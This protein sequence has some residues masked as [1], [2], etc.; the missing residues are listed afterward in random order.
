MVASTDIEIGTNICV[1]YRWS[2]WAEKLRYYGN[3]IPPALRAEICRYY[4]Q[5][6][7]DVI[8]ANMYRLENPQAEVIA[9]LTDPTFHPPAEPLGT[10]I[11]ANIDDLVTFGQSFVAALAHTTPYRPSASTTPHCIPSKTPPLLIWIT[12]NGTS[13]RALVDTGACETVISAK[14][15]QRMGWHVGAIPCQRNIPLR[16]ADLS[17]CSDQ[18]LTITQQVHITL[19]DKDNVGYEVPLG[20]ATIMQSVVCDIILGLP[21]CVGNTLII[22]TAA[23]TIFSKYL[24]ITFPTIKDLGHPEASDVA[25][26]SALRITDSNGLVLVSKDTFIPAYTA[27]VIT[28]YAEDNASGGIFVFTPFGDMAVSASQGIYEGH[29]FRVI[30]TNDG[31]D[32]L[33]PAGTPIGHTELLYPRLTP[34]LSPEICKAPEI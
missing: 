30:V 2:Y 5:C 27:T 8:M 4:P 31:S 1:A 3:E 9:A 22:D 26:I 19:R 32:V 23:R 20:S 25:L 16:N 17:P 33:L 24:N 6:H 11:P 28:V 34:I 7:P 12:A 15:A 10:P 29:T 18:G 21:F 13:C 14:F